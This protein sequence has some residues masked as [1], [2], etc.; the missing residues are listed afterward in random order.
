MND[1]TDDP[2][3]RHAFYAAMYDQVLATP[4][5]PGQRRRPGGGALRARRAIRPAPLTGIGLALA[6]AVAALVVALGVGS[7]PAPA[8][9]V[10]LHPNHLVT[11]TVHE[12]GSIDKLNA[13]LAA[14]HLRMRAVPV[15]PGCVAPVHSVSDELGPTHNDVL[16]GPART[17]E[18]TPV[19]PDTFSETIDVTPGAGRTWIL[20]VTRAGVEA[21]FAPPEAGTVVGPAPRCVG[22][23]GAPWASRS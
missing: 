8:Y 11:L 23:A 3:H 1:P 16:P 13:R 22:D 9:A 17:L 15:I 19:S 10:T 7:D 4:E 5:P 21:S 12:F 6:A 2:D 20:P 18:I 14:L